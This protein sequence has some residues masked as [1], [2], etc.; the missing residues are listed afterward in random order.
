MISTINA[1]KAKREEE[2]ANPSESVLSYKGGVP[3][4]VTKKGGDK[5]LCPENKNVGGFLI[6]AA[7]SRQEIN[8]SSTSDRRRGK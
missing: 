2:T 4:V 8:G 6:V 3:R 7:V 5:E 1:L